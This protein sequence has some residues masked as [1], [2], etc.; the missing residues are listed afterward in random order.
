[1]KAIDIRFLLMGIFFLLYGIVRKN[2][3]IV[4][5]GGSFLLYSFYSKK[6]EPTKKNIFKPELKLRGLRNR[7]RRKERKNESLSFK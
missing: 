4:I 6:M 2:I 7:N 5:V 3:F 1:M